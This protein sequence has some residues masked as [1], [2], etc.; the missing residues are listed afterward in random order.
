VNYSV[1]LGFKIALAVTVVKF[2]WDLWQAVASA[3]AGQKGFVTVF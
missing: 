1:N 3:R 2:L